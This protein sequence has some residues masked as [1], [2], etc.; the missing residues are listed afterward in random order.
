MSDE[1]I[2]LVFRG[3]GSLWKHHVFYFVVANQLKLGH[4]YHFPSRFPSV[5]LV[6]SESNV[7]NRRIVRRAVTN[8][9]QIPRALMS[10]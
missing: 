5:G 8:I 4:L 3:D 7:D 9:Q 2:C 1:E 10:P 6:F